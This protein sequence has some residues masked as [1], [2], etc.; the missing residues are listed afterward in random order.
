M[1]YLVNLTVIG[2]GLCPS[3]FLPILWDLSISLFAIWTSSFSVIFLKTGSSGFSS[4]VS[5]IPCSKRQLRREYC[6]CRSTKISN[7]VN[8]LGHF[9]WDF[10][11]QVF[12]IFVF[13]TAIFFKFL[14]FFTN[15]IYCF[16]HAYQ[17]Q[18]TFNLTFFMFFVAMHNS[19]I[20]FPKFSYSS[21]ISKYNLLI[22]GNLLKHLHLKLFQG[23]VSSSKFY[24]VFWCLVHHW[25]YYLTIFSSY[26]RNMLY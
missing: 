22:L 24:F 15:K 1:F 19:S 8:P 5:A 18:F 12:N 17:L 23:T 16:V 11:W 10:F 3:Y 20:L 2:L 6:S 13:F 7:F 21:S 9:R 4:F 25:N 14:K 26:Q